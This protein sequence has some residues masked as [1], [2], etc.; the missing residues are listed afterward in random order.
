MFLK[1]NVPFYRPWV[2]HAKRHTTL[3][4]CERRGD[5][6]HYLRFWSLFQVRIFSETTQTSLLKTYWSKPTLNRFKQETC[7]L[8]GKNRSQEDGR[9]RSRPNDLDHGSRGHGS[10]DG[11][12][13]LLR[14][15]TGRLKT[16]PK[17]YR[18]SGHSI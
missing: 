1:K 16:D 7:V 13:V 12:R 11:C 15:D 8:T 18:E 6:C 2:S 4:T 14:Y 9:V 5:L 3:P 17:K 10:G